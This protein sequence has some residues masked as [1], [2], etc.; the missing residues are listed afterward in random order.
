ML[1]YIIGVYYVGDMFLCISNFLRSGINC[2]EMFVLGLK[3]I[4]YYFKF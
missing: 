3:V 1:L 4:V 2:K